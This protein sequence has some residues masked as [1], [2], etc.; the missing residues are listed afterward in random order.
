M[1][2]YLLLLIVAMLLVVSAQDNNNGNGV[3]EPELT[4]EE[5]AMAKKA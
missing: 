3:T 2:P 1:K 4:E 5:I